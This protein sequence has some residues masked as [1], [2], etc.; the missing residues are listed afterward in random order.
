MSLQRALVDSPLGPLTLLRREGLLAGVYFEDH[1]G[2]GPLGV[3]AAWSPESF[4]AERRQLGEYFE[5]RRRSFDLRL[6]PVGTPFQQAVWQ[7]LLRIPHGETRSYGQVALA[8]GR[9]TAARAVGA[10]NARN[11]LSILVPCHRVVGASGAL[12]G[13]AGGE[14]R[15]VWLLALEREP[16]GRGRA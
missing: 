8:L 6:G 11:P 4:E 3:G 12:T 14:A 13:Y 16:E 1:R 5:G 9:P 15:K 10:A 2:R 7:E